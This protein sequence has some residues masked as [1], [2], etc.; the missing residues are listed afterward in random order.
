[1]IH[2]AFALLAATLGPEIP[3][4]PP[5]LEPAPFDNR[6]PAVAS[7]GTGFLVVWNGA[8]DKVRAARVDRD[9][10]VRDADSLLVGRAWSWWAPPAVASDGRDYV[11][12]S[13][14]HSAF[15]VDLARV[16][17][18]TGAVTP[19][20]KIAEAWLAS[21]ASNGDGYLVV[22]HRRG[23]LEAVVVDANAAIVGAPISLG[24]TEGEPRI[25]SN[26]ESYLVVSP[27]TRSD[28][29]ATLVSGGK[30]VRSEIVT[31]V[32]RG[33]PPYFGWSVATD[34]D[35]YLVAWVANGNGAFFAD[36]YVPLLRVRSFAADGTAAGASRTIAEGNVW[37]P[38]V[39][40][41]GAGYLVT[42][43][44]SPVPPWL[45][46]SQSDVRAIAVSAEGAA[47]A[48][49]EVSAT[50]EGERESA[51]ATNGA[52]TLVVWV[53]GTDNTGMVEGRLLGEEPRAISMAPAW[54]EPL[55]AMASRRDTV[56]AWSE[57]R[58]PEMRHRVILQRL[59]ARGVPRDGR[60]VPVHASPRHQGSPDLAGS[61]IVWTEWEVAGGPAS[62]W[63]KMLDAGGAPFGEAWQLGVNGNAPSVAAAGNVHL[64]VWN[65]PGEGIRAVRVDPF[66]QAVS[67][68]FAV[69]ANARDLRSEVVSDG[70]GFLVTWQRD[71]PQDSPCYPQC[72]PPRSV[73]A[74]A[75]T[76][77]GVVV[78]LPAEIGRTHFILS[79]AI[80]VWNGSEYAVFW[81]IGY[82]DGAVQARRVRRNGLP[83]GFETTAWTGLEKL[84]GAAWSGG[85]YRLVL[86]R[87]DNILHLSRDFWWQDWTQIDSRIRDLPRS[88]EL[89]N[90]YLLYL[91]PERGSRAVARRFISDK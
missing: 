23:K 83:V 41:N 75:V 81:L 89:V 52:A 19:G 44:Q 86:T 6:L 2:L 68:P 77:W 73:H 22:Y 57:L 78:G 66:A 47:G 58:A 4:S 49:V 90:G 46:R 91:S 71:E 48:P 36:S 3:L 74:V 65:A 70:S 16:D 88:V 15:S 87:P 62:V 76:R 72:I 25:A 28:L 10:M 17:A 53:R 38:A 13:S 7:N 32:S 50:V 27:L 9:G 5:A 42:Y 63:A 60:G 45:S 51:A 11:V 18:D 64:V 55:A 21:I 35:G 34:G 33:D 59:D 80:P 84:R 14:S 26:G 1:M 56:V 31:V 40:W 30:V 69:S 29:T 79:E 82:N 20:A 24:T 39:T 43:S 61:L 8:D 12:A 54:Q 67:E 37:Q 85:Q